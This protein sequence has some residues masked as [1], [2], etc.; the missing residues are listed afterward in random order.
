MKII[1]GMFF[2]ILTL[3]SS[4]TAQTLQWRALP[5]APVAPSNVGRFEDVYFVNPYI[6]WIVNLDGEIYK[7]TDGGNNW[8]LQYSDT[9]NWC[10]SVGFA[11]SL[12]GWIGF[13]V[14]NDQN[15]SV[16]YQT[17]DGGENW[18]PVNNFSDPQP[19]G[20]CGISVVNDSVVYAVG[21]I[22]N[23][24][25]LEKTTDKGNSWTSI[26]ISNY[27]K[28]AVD[29]YF[30]SPDSG[31]VVGGYADINDPDYDSLR[32]VII[33][34]SDGG[35]T[36]A[37]R[38][39]SSVRTNHCWKI[40]FSSVN[41]GYVSI[42]G[43]EFDGTILKTTDKGINWVEKTVPGIRDI[44]GVGFVNDSV[45]WVSG[46]WVSMYSTDGGNTWGSFNFWQQDDYVNRIR[47]LNDTLGYAAGKTVFK[48]SR[49]NFTSI[50]N[51]ERNDFNY[52]LKQN[53]P[54][55]FNPSTTI[56]FSIPYSG[57]VNITIYN[58]LG[59]E[60]S[61]PVNEYF[62]KGLHRINWNAGNL[63]SGVYFYKI[64]TGQY[65][66]TRKMILLH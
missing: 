55:P 33:F 2:F 16:M 39:L 30:Y 48:Y 52:S 27:I 29:C 13:L 21:T 38:Y 11:D 9:A 46:W 34:T 20:F 14:P 42:E 44:Q 65:T 56:E 10:R 61:K 25:P 18:S 15:G 64:N 37:T 17:F 4:L 58:L 45:G 1:T 32:A 41:I 7:T 50:I 60:V 62:T 19:K 59:E 51:N 8:Q 26:D 23:T 40:S 54:N 57:M 28:N 53:Y 35:E 43:A 47:F 49:E 63:A 24:S 5:N 31:F 22:A 3:I 66:S 12:R 36:W 6:G